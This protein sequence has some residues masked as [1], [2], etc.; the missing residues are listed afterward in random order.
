MNIEAIERLG[1]IRAELNQ[2]GSVRV[3]E[4]AS[5]LG[6]TGMTIRRDLDLLVDEGTA[7]RVRGGATAV[8]PE[9]FSIRQARHGRAKGRVA[10]KLME[11]VV[12]DGQTIGIDASSTMH[13]LAT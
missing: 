3:V 1:R 6:V 13:R 9:V 11:L 12:E 5:Q 8:G 2:R 7:N 4:L 10:S